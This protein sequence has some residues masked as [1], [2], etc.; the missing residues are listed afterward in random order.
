MKSVKARKIIK[1]CLWDTDIVN[2]DYKSF[3]VPKNQRDKERMMKFYRNF[4]TTEEW[5]KRVD[6]I[7]KLK[8]P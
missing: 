3:M 6:K 8:L 5:N 4:Y 1:N 2:E 7:S